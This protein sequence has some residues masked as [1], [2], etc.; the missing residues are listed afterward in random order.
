ML[1]VAM[2]MPIFHN[3]IFFCICWSGLLTSYL[4]H[5]CFFCY[6]WCL[7]SRSS[8]DGCITPKHA[9]FFPCGAFLEITPSSHPGTNSQTSWPNIRSIS[10]PETL[11]MTRWGKCSRTWRSP[12]HTGNAAGSSTWHTHGPGR[13]RISTWAKDKKASARHPQKTPAQQ[14]EPRDQKKLFIVFD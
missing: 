4:D 5:F 13:V 1:V 11:R 8:S 14:P 3:I 10:C 2:Y 12:L 9:I 7:Y 6:C